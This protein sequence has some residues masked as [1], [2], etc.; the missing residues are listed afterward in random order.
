MSGHDFSTMFSGQWDTLFSEKCQW[1]SENKIKSKNFIKKAQQKNVRFP[2]L[3]NFTWSPGLTG[4][5]K[6]I[7]SITDAPL[8]GLKQTCQQY[9]F[10]SL[11]YTDL[12]LQKNWDT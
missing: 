12:V 5:I 1:L 2:N 6:E 9:V 3:A 10:A 11:N 7:N 4:E 8:R